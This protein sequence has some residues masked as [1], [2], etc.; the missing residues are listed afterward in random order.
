MVVYALSVMIQDMFN[1]DLIGEAEHEFSDLQLEEGRPQ[2]FSKRFICHTSPS[3][4][5]G[6]VDVVQS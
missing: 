5:R 1:A 2:P 6:R 4:L 3:F